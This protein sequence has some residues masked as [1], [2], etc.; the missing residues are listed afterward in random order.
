MPS[1]PAQIKGSGASSSMA[2]RKVGGTGMSG[3]PALLAAS[4]SEYT[5]SSCPVARANWARR[6][7]SMS[8]LIDP[9]SVPTASGL[10]AMSGHF[11]VEGDHGRAAQTEVVL[12]RDVH[13]VDL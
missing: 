6:P 7:R 1:F 5:G 9:S 8:M 12:Q 2:K 10:I 3:C 11:L 4:A 13:P